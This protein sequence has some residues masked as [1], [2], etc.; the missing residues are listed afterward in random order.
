MSNLYGLYK[1]YDASFNHQY[2]AFKDDL[3]RLAN[4]NEYFKEA[5]ALACGMK[6]E[7]RTQGNYN[8]TYDPQGIVYDGT[9][10]YPVAGVRAELWTADD[11]DGANDRF[12]NDAGDY[13]QINPQITE[14]DGM[15]SWFTPEGWWQVRVFDDA[16]NVELARSEWLEV[17][18][19]HFGV[20]L[21]IGGDPFT[22]TY[23]GN[24]G[25][26]P[27]LEMLLPDPND[28]D[29]LV[30]PPIIP[31]TVFLIPKGR[32]HTAVANA[33]IRQGYE[34]VGWNTKA[35]GSG[36]T[37]QAG[38]TVANVQ[39][40]ITL[41]AQ[42]KIPSTAGTGGG[43]GG[44]EPANPNGSF[45]GG[46]VYKLGSQKNL[47]YNVT[48]D[49]AYFRDNVKIDG[50]PLVKGEDYTAEGNP[51][52][53]TLLAAYLETLPVGE[54]TI[55]VSFNDGT[56]AT[57]TFT[58]EEGGTAKDGG[59][60]GDDGPTTVTPTAPVN[61]FEDVSGTDWFVDSVIYIYEKGLM[62]GTSTSP[63]LFSPDMPLTRGMIVTVL[64]R[65]AGSPIL[66]GT[67]SPDG[68]NGT[69]GANSAGNPFDDVNAGE[70]YTD[71]VIWA[72]ANGIVNG[73]GD[74]NFG[75]EDNITRQDL[76]AILVRY[77]EFAGITLP[78]SR[79]Y[80]VFSDDSTI[81]DYAKEA[82]ESLYRAAIVN[83]YPDGAF[84]PEWEATRAEFATM[85]MNFLLAAG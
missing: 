59:T 31:Q 79:E 34:F 44:K 85:L 72:A 42:W 66:S 58:V 68:A 18:P 71:A 36:T 17:L 52:K 47:V 69:S 24:G 43:S 76:A 7:D 5:S 56:R 38:A 20:D 14:D 67:G 50:E 54:H 30:N 70:W 55:V 32:N 28:P 84:E 75:P 26:L 41:Y 78:V 25:E 21:N 16:T 83:G 27:T 23:D 15:F 35:D 29:F 51:T 10:D 8:F 53:I 64:F 46:S 81:A 82:V 6:D 49:F 63:M 40:N 80:A 4:F 65:L 45:A 74:G 3:A 33:F 37:Y 61:P 77:A 60:T 9:S 39:A 48:K 19:P 2:E 1:N 57:A 12:W 62:N 13:D 11:G 22:I 73:Y